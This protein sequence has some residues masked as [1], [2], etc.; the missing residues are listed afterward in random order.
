MD[1]VNQFEIPI[2]LVGTLWKALESENFTLNLAENEENLKRNF[3]LE[4]KKLDILT[5]S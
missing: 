1:D 4:L 2:E 5:A 3:G